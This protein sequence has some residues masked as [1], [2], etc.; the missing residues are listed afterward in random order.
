ME[1]ALKAK[2]VEG[3]ELV[4]DEA[5]KRAFANHTLAGQGLSCDTKGKKQ[6]GGMVGML[7]DIFVGAKAGLAGKAAGPA[8]VHHRIETA[9]NG[10]GGRKAKDQF[11]SRGHGGVGGRI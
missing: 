11:E 9:G 5:V 1:T 10:E 2:A 3:L 6:K 7:S 4:A 8:G